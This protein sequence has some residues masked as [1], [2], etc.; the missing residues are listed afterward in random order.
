MRAACWIFSS[1]TSN[2][3]SIARSICSLA[4]SPIRRTCSATLWMA[5]DVDPK[6]RRSRCGR[7]NTSISGS[8]ESSAAE[9]SG[10]FSRIIFPESSTRIFANGNNTNVFVIL[11]MVWKTEMPTLVTLPL[12]NAGF[13]VNTT[14]ISTPKIKAPSTLNN[15]WMT[16]ALFAVRF[17]PALDRRAVTHVPMFCP[18]VI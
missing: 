10:S 5:K 15:K 8:C 3:L 18:N 1:L 13:I 14:N 7:S 11:N 4:S 12:A 16:A 17:A 6:I 2:T 9:S